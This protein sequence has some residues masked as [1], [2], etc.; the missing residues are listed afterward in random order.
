MVAIPGQGDAGPNGGPAGD[1]Y[2]FIHVR[3]HEYFERDGNDLYCALP[4]SLT[5]A[6]LG[7]EIAMTTIEGKKIKVSVPGG[8]QNGRMLRVRDEG[9]AIGLGPPRRPLSQAPRP[10]TPAS[11]EAG[12]GA[13]RGI[14]HGGRRG[15]RTKAHQAFR[16]QVLSK[17]GPECPFF[18]AK[19]VLGDGLFLY[20]S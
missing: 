1:L 5:M 19:A 8:S 16:S 13:P 6:T 9:V 15:R 4:I 7:G 3:P 14:P 11:L 18:I 12:Q 17:P 10:G 20:G 2:V